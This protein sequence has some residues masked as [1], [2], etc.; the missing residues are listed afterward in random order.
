METEISKC[1]NK[2]ISSFRL[3]E[4][5][6]VS[7]QFDEIENILD[8]N[9][10]DQENSN[11]IS[12]LVLPIFYP[13]DA[14]NSR[15]KFSIQC[16]ACSH[17]IK[18]APEFQFDILVSIMDIFQQY[19]HI[20][21]GKTSIKNVLIDFFFYVKD[22]WDIFNNACQGRSNDFIWCFFIFCFN[23]IENAQKKSNWD[24]VLH[25]A[26]DDDLFKSRKISEILDFFEKV[27]FCWGANPTI[28]STLTDQ[29]LNFIL[30]GAD[31]PPFLYDSKLQASSIEEKTIRAISLHLSDSTPLTARSLSLISRQDGNFQSPIYQISLFLA[32][33][34]KS[35][36]NFKNTLAQ[37]IKTFIQRT[38]F[39]EKVAAH[40]VAAAS[41]CQVNDFSII[42]IFSEEF[43]SNEQKTSLFFAYLADCSQSLDL[44]STIPMINDAF[45]SVQSSGPAYGVCKLISSLLNKCRLHTEI[46]SE[47]DIDSLRNYIDFF[48][49]VVDEQCAKSASITDIDKMV[50]LTSKI[51]AK[52]GH[53]CNQQIILPLNQPNVCQLYFTCSVCLSSLSYSSEL[54]FPLDYACI[55]Y[56][57]S[58][59]NQF[60]E[61]SS[62]IKA[63]VC[64]ILSTV[65]FPPNDFRFSSENARILFNVSLKSFRMKS[66][67]IEIFYDTIKKFL[68]SLKSAES[69]LCDFIRNFWNEK[70]YSDTP[71]D[72]ISLLLAVYDDY[73]DFFKYFVAMIKTNPTIFFEQICGFVNSFSFR[74]WLIYKFLSACCYYI[75]NAFKICKKIYLTQSEF[76]C[77]IPALKKVLPK[78]GAQTSIRAAAIKFV[79]RYFD[80]CP[81]LTKYCVTESINMLL[82]KNEHTEFPS[83]EELGVLT[84]INETNQ[85]IILS[86]EL[87]AFTYIDNRNAP[88]MELKASLF[89]LKKSIDNNSELI[90]D[91]ELDSIHKSLRRSNDPRIRKSYLKFLASLG[92]KGM[93]YAC[94]ISSNVPVTPFF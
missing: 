3:L 44:N 92:L 34:Q 17:L 70:V 1:V 41:L 56:A 93:P 89:I 33:L 5:S 54:P 59:F 86:T 75:P 13:G 2:I 8:G 39:T 77:F 46:L 4:Y 9:T 6:S 60:E 26:S 35:P 69:I 62:K 63:H 25:L 27:Y 38:S 80:F 72:S 15:L 64:R 21:I 51:I 36:L 11:K 40:I 67:S 20:F 22:P 78:T 29:S 24:L 28:S 90:S 12:A 19:P 57:I 37:R 53:L 76:K 84:D 85:M 42:D 94:Q 23:Y 58:E 88:S 68:P 81:P 10:L 7:A 55:S 47:S 83:D 71:N 65:N 82:R 74:H 30:R 79:G 16:M 61:I 32:I 91:V 14:S 73:D 66:C 48:I 50:K 43:S 49:N 45:V 18:L 87:N 52:L 31:I